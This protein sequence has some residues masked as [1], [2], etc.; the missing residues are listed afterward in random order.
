M[1]MTKLKEH[2]ESLRKYISKTDSKYL[3]NY[4]ENL[5]VHPIPF[6]GNIETAKV[7]TVGAN[8]SNGEF[9]KNRDWLEEI[10]N[11]DLKNRLLKYFNL[12]IEPHPWFGIWEES[13]QLLDSSYY[14]GTAAHVDLSPRATFSMSSVKDKNKFE[15]MVEND[16]VWFF[17][18]L[19]LCSR[20]KLLLIAGTI[21]NKYYIN[22]FIQEHSPSHGFKLS[23][24]F[25]PKKVPGRAKWFR[26]TLKSNVK[27]YP[28]YFCSVSPSERTNPYLLVERI[29][30]HK[31]K[32]LKHLM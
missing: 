9:N 11:T 26:H 13:L 15:E 20:V 29:A 14:N 10:T 23:P 3:T 21:T 25:D 17:K 19:P 28:L 32:L 6:F 5:V 31:E 4:R 30:E 18:L 16:V 7:L 27:T 24:R 22:E 2:I 12:S 8:P 1:A